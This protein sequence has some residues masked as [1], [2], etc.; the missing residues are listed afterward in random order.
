[1]KGFDLARLGR[2]IRLRR[3]ALGWSIED[4]AEACGVTGTYLG[5]VENGLRD[6]H[7]MM[8]VSIA[9]GLGCS[10]ADLLVEP[11]G[12]VSPRGRQMGRLFDRISP[13]AQ[14]MVALL[15][16]ALVRPRKEEARQGDDAGKSPP[17]PE[18]G[19]PPS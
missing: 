8:L 7:V 6:P 18:E 1:M 13:R 12:D 16:Y 4:F 3:L 14:E 9:K 15:L 2:E 17:P 11:H 5:V 19:E 10:V